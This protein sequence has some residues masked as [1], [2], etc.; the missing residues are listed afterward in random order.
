MPEPGSIDDLIRSTLPEVGA[1]MRAAFDAV[2]GS[3]VSG[4]E[5]NQLGL[6]DGVEIVLQY[7]DVGEPGIALDH[8]LYM[9][10]E[11]GLDVSPGTYAAI[12]EAGT[13]MGLPAAK[14]ERVRPSH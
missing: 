13:L 9:I 10:H 11:P 7:L 8:L 4:S 3:P 6:I 14:W 1:L 12:A 2:A 5:P